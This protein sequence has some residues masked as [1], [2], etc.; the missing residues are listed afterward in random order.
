[1]EAE[2]DEY[3]SPWKLAIEQY[4]PEFMGFYFP[5]AYQEIDW[6][7][8][9]VFLEQELRAVQQDAELGRRIVDK[10]VRI[11]LLDG[12]ENWIYIHLEVQASRQAEFAERMFVYNYRLYDRYRRPIVSM[13]VLADEHL[14]WRPTSFGYDILGCKHSLEFP[15]AKLADYHDQVEELL[16]M[17]N[18]F[19]WLTAAHILT[20]QTR[21]QVQQRYE[22]K[23]RLVRI[24]YQR[25]WNKQRIINLF[26]VLDWLMSLPEELE[27]RIWQEVADIEESENMQYITSVERIGIAKGRVEGR[28]QGLE[29]GLQ[30]GRQEGRMEGQQAGRQEEAAKLFLLLLDSKFGEVGQNIREKIRTASPEEIE[31]WTKQVFQADS[32]EALLNT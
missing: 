12:N 31:N 25:Q 10:L 21:K 20:Q 6:G 5:E 19:A 24:L 22:A 7:V 8:D 17:E 1:M 28:Q 32:L 3:D 11:S 26:I 2:N 27:Q 15:V 16:V 14:L 9:Y 13:A 29:E 4:F 23:L 18:A 30:K